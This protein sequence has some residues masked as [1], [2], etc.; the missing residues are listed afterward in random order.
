MFVKAADVD[1]T[2]SR[3]ATSA[4]LWSRQAGGAMGKEYIVCTAGCLTGVENR[5]KQGDN[6]DRF[7]RSPKTGIHFVNAFNDRNQVDGTT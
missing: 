1:E 7:S 5:R 2:G 4:E 3:I 6:H